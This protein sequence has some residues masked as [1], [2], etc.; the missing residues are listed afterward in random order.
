MSRQNNIL[1]IDSNLKNS[2]TMKKV[3]VIFSLMIFSSQLFAQENNKQITRCPNGYYLHDGECVPKAKIVDNKGKKL[4]A[5]SYVTDFVM[6]DAEI[7]K[8]FGGE[9]IIIKK[10]EYK[11]DY[12]ENKLGNVTLTLAKPLKVLDNKFTER[13]FQGFRCDGS[14]KEEG[15]TCFTCKTSSNMN[16]K[17]PTF[18]LLPIIEGEKIVK[19][20]IQ[21]KGAGS[22]KSAGF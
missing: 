11:I 13:I 4:Q 22:P 19:L 16:A 20:E 17:P 1:E 8:H 6:D 12:S 3:F 18:I 7:V 15:P 21:W 5:M 10:G 2:K 14:C 9:Q